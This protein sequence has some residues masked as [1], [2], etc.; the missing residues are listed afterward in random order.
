MANSGGGVIVFGV[1]SNGAGVAFDDTRL[2]R[3]DPADITN[4]IA[5]Y[6]GRQFADFETAT[7]RR[8]RTE[9]VALLV[10]AATSAP[11]VFSREGAY[12]S[13]TGRDK[14]AFH[15]GTIYARHGAKSEP[16]NEE[17]IRSMIEREVERLRDSWLDGI[18]KITTAPSGSVVQ[19]V[20]GGVLTNEQDAT[21]VRIV[22][23][24]QAPEMRPADGD[25]NWPLT[26]TQLYEE[27]NARLGRD[28]MNLH[29][30]ACLRRVYRLAEERPTLAYRPFASNPT[31]Y[32]E[33]CVH[34]I[35]SSFEADPQFFRDAR[36]RYRDLIA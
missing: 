28:C 22:G 25:N 29:D 33:A 12:L 2:R 34:W 10:G 3:L 26:A 8:R 23:D 35:V 7:V 9:R 18:K 36:R 15:K 5:A 21:P 1:R 19:V 32:S 20:D 17:D 16:A 14:L 27:V 24:E 4:K 11:L 31:R 30:V 13:P 6:T